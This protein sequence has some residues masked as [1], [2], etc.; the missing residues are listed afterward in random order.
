[1]LRWAIVDVVDAEGTVVANRV[2]LSFSAP[3]QV[4]KLW[5]AWMECIK[6]AST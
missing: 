5:H 4:A 1:M 3:P 6:T 2:E